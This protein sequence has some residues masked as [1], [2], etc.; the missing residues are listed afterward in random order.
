MNLF[1]ENDGNE[2]VGLKRLTCNG[3]L[4]VCNHPTVK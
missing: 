4:G 3:L 2:I 1:Y